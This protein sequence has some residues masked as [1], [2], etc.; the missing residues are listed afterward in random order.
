M[1]PVTKWKVYCLTISAK[2]GASFY[3]QLL[4]NKVSDTNN[5]NNNNNNNNS[6]NNNNN[7]FIFPVISNKLHR[8]KLF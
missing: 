3:H 7:R 8:I 1:S 4:L 2:T 6:N 5:N